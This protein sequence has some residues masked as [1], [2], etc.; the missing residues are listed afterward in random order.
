MAIT[1]PCQV[2]V[3]IVEG[4]EERLMLVG[5]LVAGEFTVPT[6]E[7]RSPLHGIKT[8]A[9]SKPIRFDLGILSD[10]LEPEPLDTGTAS[11]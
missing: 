9:P 2:K 5:E 1:M 8:L 11:G 6:V 3:Y 4:G 10:G 7:I